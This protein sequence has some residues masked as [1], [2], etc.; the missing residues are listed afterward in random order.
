MINE[1]YMIFIAIIA[2]FFVLLI[3]KKILDGKKFAKKVC[4]LCG[5]VTMV[6]ITLLLL[7]WTGIYTN[8]TMVALLMGGSVVGILYSAEQHLKERL[9]LFRLPFYLSL[10]LVS[11]V[12]I[13]GALDLPSFGIIVFVWIVFILLYIYQRDA[14]FKGIVDR[15]I[16]CCRDW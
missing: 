8:K 14:R 11:Y 3:V 7:L 10:L 1:P 9:K 16:A 2:G 5:A 6:W 4:A 13:N 12:A 15:I